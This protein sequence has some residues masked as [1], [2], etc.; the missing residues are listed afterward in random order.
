MSTAQA[1]RR[2]HEPHLPLI[3]A[4]DY[5]ALYVSACGQLTRHAEL[6]ICTDGSYT[7]SA[8]IH[9]PRNALP[10]FSQWHRP[11]ALRPELQWMAQNMRAGTSVVITGRGLWLSQLAGEPVLCL[12]ECTGIARADFCVFDPAPSE[13]R[14]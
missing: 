5:Q 9:Q 1:A 6:R 13:A 10:L 14:A 4:P 7:L 2:V 11:A 3:P 12:R 8:L